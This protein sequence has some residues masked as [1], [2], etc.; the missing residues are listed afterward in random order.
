M[1]LSTWLLQFSIFNQGTTLSH[2]DIPWLYALHW[3]M[4]IIEGGLLL[5]TRTEHLCSSSHTCR[6][7][8]YS[9]R[10]TLAKRDPWAILAP[11]M[12][13]QLFREVKED[14]FIVWKLLENVLSS[15]P[16]LDPIPYFGA[17]YGALT[18]SLNYIEVW[19]STNVKVIVFNGH[20][21][22]HSVHSHFLCYLFSLIEG[23][24][25]ICSSS[26]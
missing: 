4:D 3:H 7:K 9:R 26:V 20:Q 22:Y 8:P 15:L 6:L 19:I 21:T 1:T 16:W 5:G 14:L 17:K 12:W 11:K 2:E 18:Q 10:V 25:G 24:K 13:L 23:Y